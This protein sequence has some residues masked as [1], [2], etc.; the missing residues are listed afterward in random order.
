MA[1]EPLRICKQAVCESVSFQIKVVN[2]LNI[3]DSFNNTLYYN[4]L[5]KSRN[6]FEFEN[7]LISSDS[8]FILRH[9]WM[10]LGIESTR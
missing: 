9:I 5:K 2:F 1:M 8:S 6:G 10:R 3:A 7:A 4:K